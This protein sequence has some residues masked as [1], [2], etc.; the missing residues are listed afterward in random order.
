MKNS[1][2]IFFAVNLKPE[3]KIQKLCKLFRQEF[4][5]SK[6]SWC[7]NS[8]LHLTLFFIGDFKFDQIP[9][10]LGELEKVNYQNFV[11]IKSDFSLKG[12]GFFKNKSTI[13]WLGVVD[14]SKSLFQLHSLLQNLIADKFSDNLNKNINKSKFKPHITLARIKDL[15]KQDNY[16]FNKILKDYKS[17][18]FQ[19][20][21]L[22]Y[23]SLMES[24]LTHLGPIYK[25]LA[26][27]YLV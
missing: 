24:T 11:K 8:Y 17:T 12:V 15:T 21:Q 3:D 2:R 22:E 16:F 5:D 1:K 13:L 6:I 20:F 19:Q 23:Y 4:C 26:R 18:L 9:K 25:E 7:D 14:K 10:L 27:I